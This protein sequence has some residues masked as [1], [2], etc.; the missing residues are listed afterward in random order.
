[1]PVTPSDIVKFIE[2]RPG[3]PLSAREIAEG[4]RISP[5]QR[6]KFYRLLESLAT[7]GLVAHLKGDR[8]SL[9]RKQNLVTGTIS[10]HR[11]GYGFVSPREG[12]GPDVFV[13]ARFLREVMHGDEIVVRVERGGRPGKPEG[14][15][16]R[17]EKR[18]HT[19]LVGLYEQG[20]KFGS[21]HP[22][23]PRLNQ[24]IFVPAGQELG[25]RG[26]EV[27]LVA[28][29]AYPN[30][31]RNAEGHIVQVL[32]DPSD[33][34]VE[35]L[36]IIHKHGLSH[37]FPD[38]VLAEADFLP[39]EVQPGDLEQREDLR[40]LPFV[41]IDGETAK[42]F[43]DAVCLRC[44]EGGTSR[45]W[46]AIADVGHYVKEG[47]LLDQEAYLRG[48][49]V[50][51]PGQVIPMLP[52]RLSNGICSLNPQVDRLTLVAEIVFDAKARRQSSRFYP[53]VIRSRARLTYT[54]VHEMVEKQLAETIERYVDL[55]PMLTE[56]LAL[57]E[58]LTAMRR[59]RGSLDFDLPEAEIILGV[60]GEPENIIKAERTKAHR[61]IE[62]F[63]LAA[64]EAVA[65]FLDQ[66]DF[67]LLY[68]VHEPPDLAK[69]QAF[70]Q[71]IAFFNYGFNLEAEGVD[72]RAL[73][74]LLAQVEGKPEERTINQVLLRSMK[75]AFYAPDNVGHFGLAAEHYCHF[76]SPIRRYPD[77]QVHRVLRQAWR[78][79][80]LAEQERKR[81][82][83]R[84]PE[85]GEHT[86][87]T[88]RRAMEAEREIVE[89]KKCQFMAE[90]VGETF[91]GYITGVQPF[92]L[93]VE[94]KE[95][96][97]EG[98]VH[99]T[100]LSDDFYTYEEDRHRL[101]GQYR[102]RIFQVGNEVEVLVQ[103]VSVERREIDFTL[104]DLA[105]QQTTAQ[106]P[107]KGR[108]AQGKSKKR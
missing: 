48:T 53:A 8:Y 56:M 9:P 54:E 10:V 32:G 103:N 6:K 65:F 18:A 71:F 36:S 66:R 90:R 25:A 108:R 61:L 26:G 5:S 22:A 51:F 27:V 93:F 74:E 43:D 84:L 98:L 37:E 81:L 63:M 101:V 96:F 102:R 14:R 12:Q 70:Q 55:Y 23:D 38:D 87:R 68:R 21:V 79:G 39:E 104:V 82:A 52:E 106:E 57:S 45:L 100:S 60:R 75:Q 105:A 24:P 42:D 15:L 35:I 94:L 46:V 86:S 29:D 73:Q 62:E 20:R 64:N 91:A 69:L 2:S 40:D 34:A 97:V 76:T 49:S 7:E 11:D 85:M 88:E 58:G 50:Y 89:L 78:T 30:E 17:V 41:T 77:L 47:S 33:P 99:L 3:R 95:F 59:Q 13:P 16:V 1:M 4:L 19:T 67:P 80:G 107:P 28:I 44:E 83:E 31:F 92:G 72:P